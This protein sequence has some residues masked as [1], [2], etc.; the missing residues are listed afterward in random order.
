MNAE[1]VRR[2]YLLHGGSPVDTAE[3]LGVSR[4]AIYQAL[5]TANRRTPLT[6]PTLTLDVPGMHKDDQAA[7]AAYV[8]A[9]LLKAGILK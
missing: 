5:A 8:R 4:S 6:V 7:I 2:H 1:E 9:Q 3:T